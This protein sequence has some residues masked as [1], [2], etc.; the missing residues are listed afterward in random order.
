MGRLLLHSSFSIA[1]DDFRATVAASS[2]I[3]QRTCSVDEGT[4]VAPILSSPPPPILS[5]KPRPSQLLSRG[6]PAVLPPAGETGPAIDLC[7]L[8]L[9]SKVGLCEIR[10]KTL[11]WSR[12]WGQR[13]QLLCPKF[14]LRKIQALMSLW[15]LLYIQIEFQTPYSPS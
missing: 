12:I 13:L 1:W 7:S 5:L 3:T 14:D 2:Q 8:G 15:E 10:R 11:V 6:H 4:G 9:G